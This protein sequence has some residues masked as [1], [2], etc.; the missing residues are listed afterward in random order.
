[1]LGRLMKWK[2]NRKRD[3]EKTKDEISQEKKEQI[4][5]IRDECPFES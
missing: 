1:M 3:Q 5:N 4:T 2:R